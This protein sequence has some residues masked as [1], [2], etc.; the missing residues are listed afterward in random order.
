MNGQ[1]PFQPRVLAA[2]GAAL[3]ALFAAS[4]LPTGAGGN[5]VTGDPVGAN[6]YSRSAV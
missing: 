3:V 2:L 1:S 4:M 6:T 5:R